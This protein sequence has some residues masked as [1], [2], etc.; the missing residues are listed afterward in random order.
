MELEPVERKRQRPDFDKKKPKAFSVNYHVAYNGIRTVVCK[1][2]FLSIFR[3][4]SKQ[5][6]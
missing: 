3:I 2:A 4:T 6:Y 5:C 1:Q